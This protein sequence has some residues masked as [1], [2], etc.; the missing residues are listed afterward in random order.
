MES[1]FFV[2][3]L[4]NVRG[5]SPVL[6]VGMTNDLPRR[7]SEHEMATTGFV[8]KYRVRTL[9]YVETASSPAA[10]IAREKQ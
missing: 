7:L 5:K 3:I 4:A 2:Y 1:D 6:Y 9:V 10:A 8:A